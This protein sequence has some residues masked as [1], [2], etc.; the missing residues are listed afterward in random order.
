MNGGTAVERRVHPG[1]VALRFVKDLPQTII[2]LPA[3]F[4]LA[5]DTG[6]AYVL[7]VAF[8]ALLLL[9]LVQWLAWSR[10]QYGVGAEEIVIQSGILSR[11]RR[12]IPFDRVQD[13]DIERGPLHRLFG[14]AKVRI[15]TGGSAK[16]EGV[17]DS[18]TLDEAARLRAAIRAGRHA[19]EPVSPDM[20]AAQEEARPI[21]AMSPG[22]VFA[23]G[24][25]NFS[26]VHLAGIFAVLQTFEPL[27]PFDIEDP[28]RWIGLVDEQTVRG[29]TPGA[30]LAVLMVAILLGVVTGLVRTLSTDWGFRVTGE[31]ARL[32]FER[33]LLTRRE[34]VIPKNRIQLALI[35]SGPVRRAF[36]YAEL[37]FQ[38]LTAGKGGGGQHSVAP[39][40]NSGEVARM[41]GEAPRL[42]LPEPAAMQRVSSHHITRSAIRNVAVPL[43][44]IFAASLLRAEA[45]L[46]LPIVPLLLASAFIRRRVHRYALK[47]ETLFVRDGLWRQ[48]LWI[49]PIRHAQAVTIRRSILQR[50]LGLATL[51]VD[52]AG[53]P[54]LNEVR[55]VDLVLERARALMNEVAAGGVSA[56]QPSDCCA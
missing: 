20:S 37:F 11:N 50:W 27:I 16:D 22:R 46:L 5:S 13:V 30:W 39:F 33:G 32:R 17:L 38:T 31:G 53:A 48:Q 12:S 15:E 35:R 49:V 40:A 25:F 41:L 8:A 1:T 56:R 6:W 9:L 10:F 34:V 7:P 55:I 24:F 26:L 14:L 4:A 21:L 52:T 3:L 28:G 18:V 2:G 43:L 47:G 51:A 36:G 19:E 44:L 23:S 54:M 42:R 45:L 29:F